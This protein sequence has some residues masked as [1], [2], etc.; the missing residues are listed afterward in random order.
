MI[1]RSIGISLR[2]EWSAICMLRPIMLQTASIFILIL[3]LQHLI[4]STTF[5]RPLHICIISLTIFFFE[6]YSFVICS[7]SSVINYSSFHSLNYSQNNELVQT[8]RTRMTLLIREC[9]R[10][11]LSKLAIDRWVTFFKEDNNKAQK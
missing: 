1:F 7:L 6:D 9:L 4:F 10:W 11:K 2:L 5:S 3:L 8:P